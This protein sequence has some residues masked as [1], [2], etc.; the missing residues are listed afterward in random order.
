MTTLCKDCAHVYVVGKNDPSWK[1]LCMKKPRE[2]E[3]NYQTGETVADPAWERCRHINYG[4]CI[5]FD[6]GPN[7]LKPRTVLE[8]L[9]GET[10]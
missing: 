5:H 9:E 6:A 7:S 8:H 4:N 2:Q 3:F 1:W 10:A